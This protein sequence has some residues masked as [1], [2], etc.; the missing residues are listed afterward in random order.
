[1][2]DQLGGV[3]T[4]PISA[5]PCRLTF[6]ALARLIGNEIPGGG[7]AARGSAGGLR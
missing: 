1:V 4:T 2:A 7:L 3:Q 6:L 5:G